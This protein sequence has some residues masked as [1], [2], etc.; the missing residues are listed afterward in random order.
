MAGY[1]FFVKSIT[2]YLEFFHCFCAKTTENNENTHREK[3][4]EYKDIFI[5]GPGYTRVFV[6]G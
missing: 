3:L 6:L 2:E 4:Y 1:P 5:A